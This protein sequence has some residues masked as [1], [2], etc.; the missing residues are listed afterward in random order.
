MRDHP[1]VC[2]EHHSARSPQLGQTG[3]SPRVRGTLE[4]VPRRVAAGGIIPA[5]A[6]NTRWWSYTPRQGGDHPRV[7]GEHARPLTTG[8]RSSGIIPACA[9]NTLIRA[10]RGVNERNHPRVCGEHAGKGL[11]LDNYTGSSPRVRGTLGLEVRDGPVLGIIPACAGNTRPSC[12]LSWSRRDHP[13]VCGEH[14]WPFGA[15]SRILESSPRV[16]GT[17][18]ELGVLHHDVGI[19]PACAGNTRR[20]AIPFATEWDHPRVCGEHRCT[21]S[22]RD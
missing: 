13:R 7:C 16:R 15:V 11:T 17:H 4:R 22:R 14:V 12:P 9:G 8:A 18:G 20:R 1:R 6:G 3:S 5:C 21:T 19:I 2:G 10:A